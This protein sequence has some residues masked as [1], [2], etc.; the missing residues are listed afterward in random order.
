MP[1]PSLY[2]GTSTKVTVTQEVLARMT[3]YNLNAYNI[4]KTSFQQSL[5][6]TACSQVDPQQEVQ[7]QARQEYAVT[8]VVTVSRTELETQEKIGATCDLDW[9]LSLFQERLW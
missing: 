2:K 9:R 5:L 1:D 4:Y 7:L 6:Y 8:A 3:A